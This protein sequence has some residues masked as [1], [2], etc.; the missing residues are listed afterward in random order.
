MATATKERAK[1]KATPLAEPVSYYNARV[2]HEQ[3]RVG[4]EAYLRRFRRGRFEAT[5]E[6]EEAAVR[7]ALRA[8]GLNKPDRWRG[9][10]IGPDNA[11]V[12]KK[13]GFTT[14]N[15]N[16]WWDHQGYEMH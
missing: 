11:R 15:E 9:D 10:D 7:A 13:C 4:D 8:Y 6:E 16:A 2:I 3:F 1:A 14:R 12:C 5:T